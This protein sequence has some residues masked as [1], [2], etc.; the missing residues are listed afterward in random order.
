MTKD[1]MKRNTYHDY[2]AFDIHYAAFKRGQERKLEKMI[3][4]KVCKNCGYL[5][6]KQVV[7]I[8]EEA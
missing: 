6:G 8:G 2:M 1:Y 3:R 5:D 7:A 4:R